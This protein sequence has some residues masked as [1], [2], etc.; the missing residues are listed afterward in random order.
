MSIKDRKDRDREKMKKLILDASLKLFIS[1]DYSRISMRKIAEKIEYS[2]GTIYLYFKNKDEILYELHNMAFDKFYRE[3]QKVNSIKEPFEKLREHGKI[4]INFAINNPEYYELMFIMNATGIEIEK[5]SNWYAGKRTFEFL[6]Q[7]IQECL[8][9]G[10]FKSH[11]VFSASMAMWSFVHGIVSLYLRK[12][13]A[14]IPSENQKD[15]MF[16]AYEF[17]MINTGKK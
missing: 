7:N 9:N 10:Y 3:Q 8:D 15:V 13:M 12:R 14:M 17:F 5:K 16:A 2:P 6:M 11:D 4:Y 1:E